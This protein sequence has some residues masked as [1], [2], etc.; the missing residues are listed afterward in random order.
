MLARIVHNA[1]K[2]F[3]IYLNSVHFESIQRKELKQNEVETHFNYEYKEQT[4]DVWRRGYRRVTDKIEPGNDLS[5]YIK[6]TY[7]IVVGARTTS[8]ISEGTITHGNRWLRRSITHGKVICLRKRQST[9]K[10]LEIIRVI[11]NNIEYFN[12]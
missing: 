6:L 2:N 3:I 10:N 7:A 9:S 12:S 8:G 4:I 5:N 1:V 11:Y